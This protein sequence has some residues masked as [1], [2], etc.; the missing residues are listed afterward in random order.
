M[1]SSKFGCS[2][3]ETGASALGVLPGKLGYRE[4]YIWGAYIYMP[5]PYNREAPNGDDNWQWV[6]LNIKR[7]N[8]ES[9][10]ARRTKNVGHCNLNRDRINLRQLPRHSAMA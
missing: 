2:V 1:A 7:I 4:K 6:Q 9:G 8:T 5:P 3:F 10:K